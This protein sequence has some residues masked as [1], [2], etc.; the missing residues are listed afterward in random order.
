[1]NLT[2]ANRPLR[3][4][5]KVLSGGLGQGNVGVVMAKHGLG[6]VA[7]LT[8]IAI[9]HAMDSRNALHVSVGKSVSSVRAFHD[10]VLSE[11]LESLGATSDRGTHLTNVERHKQIYS[12]P[13]AN[14]FDVEKLESTIEFL[15]QHAGFCSEMIELSGW[16]GFENLDPSVMG[17]LKSLAKKWNTELW[18]SAHVE[19]DMEVD[20]KGIPGSIARCLDDIE[21]LVA[22]ESE[23]DHVNL[24]FLKTHGEPKSTSVHLQFDPKS[25]LIRWR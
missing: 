17:A 7:V 11:I 24:K 19:G 3:V 20:D 25:M 2:D 6:K 22:L 12:F 9:D 8:S 15:D 1:M 21:V 4:L 14:S 10:E 18:I 5:D 16:P 13:D 23:S